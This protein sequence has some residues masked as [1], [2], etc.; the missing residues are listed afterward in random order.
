MA[1]LKFRIVTFLGCFSLLLM[2][3]SDQPT[4]PDA[5]GGLYA[6]ASNSILS[7]PN[8][9]FFSGYTASELWDYIV[10]TDTSLAVG[11]RPPGEAEGVRGADILVT[12]AQRMRAETAVAAVANAEIVDRS[13]LLPAVRVKV[14]DSLAIKALLDFPLLEYVEPAIMV[15]ESMSYLAGGCSSSGSASDWEEPVTYVGGDVMPW[16]YEEQHMDV[17]RAWI[18]SQGS[19]ITVGVIDTGVDPAQ[20][21]LNGLFTAGQSGGRVKSFDASSTSTMDPP[22]WQDDCG[23][24]THVAS[25]IAAPKG[26]GN[27]VGVAWKAN[28]SAVRHHD[29]VWNTLGD[30]WEAAEAIRISVEDHF[31][32]IIAMAFASDDNGNHLSNMIEVK[33]ANDDVLF[34]G[35]AG[36]T[37]EPGPICHGF[38]GVQFPANMPEVM[39]V[40]GARHDGSDMAAC[41][42]HYGPEVEVMA[43]TEMPAAGAVSLLYEEDLAKTTGSSNA[44]ALIAGI[45]ALVW[46]Q[47]PSWDASQVRTRLKIAG[48]RD[49]KDPDFGYGVV[50]AFE[51]VGGLNYVDVEGP[52][53]VYPEAAT[54][55]AYSADRHIGFGPF[56]YQWSV[57]PNIGISGGSTASPTLTVGPEDQPAFNITLTVTDQYDGTIASRTET[58][59]VAD[60]ECQQHEG[61]CNN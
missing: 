33:S 6:T 49:F 4:V 60:P 27:I 61:D 47:N 5:P 13:P 8:G 38:N 26:T 44:T 17:R 43:M 28:L 56:I 40:T 58:V 3:C 36:T 50:D 51:A 52:T 39:A 31:A 7:R 24:G 1:N 41:G 45:A 30:A 25:V 54:Q 9:K 37:P 34:I 46:S 42:S 32:D 35:A 16:N 22:A 14:R 23:H 15:N 12:A 21:E 10:R 53:A 18:H 19:G 2:G 11:F 59:Q 55:Y 48:S 29:D 20:D 57:P